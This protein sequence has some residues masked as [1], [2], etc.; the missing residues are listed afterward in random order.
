LPRLLD[1][2]IAVGTLDLTAHIL[3]IGTT[4]QL[5]AAGLDAGPGETDELGDEG[6]YIRSQ[7]TGERPRILIT[8]NSETALLTGTFH[9]LRLLQ[10]QQGI[11][12][13][14]ILSQPRMQPAHPGALGQP[15]WFNRARLCRSIPVE[16]GRIAR[17]D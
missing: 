14:N 9:F 13:L 1:R 10:T 5:Q 12:D 16:V 4:G 3:V 17:A 8:G 11:H 7:E 15:G 2:P 6:F